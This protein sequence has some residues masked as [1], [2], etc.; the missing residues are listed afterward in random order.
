MTWIVIVKKNNDWIVEVTETCSETHSITS[1]GT[2]PF[3]TEEE[4]EEWAATLRYLSAVPSYKDMPLNSQEDYRFYKFWGASEILL[5]TSW[6]R[7]YDY[8]NWHTSAS[9]EVDGQ[10]M[11]DDWDTFAF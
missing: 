2:W 11:E 3:R 8:Y 4:A 7:T 6:L 5:P 1:G 10:Y 9:L